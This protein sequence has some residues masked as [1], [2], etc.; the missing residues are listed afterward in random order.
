MLYE[1][2]RV[3]LYDCKMLTT[4]ESVKKVTKLIVPG[5]ESEDRSEENK[6]QLKA[7]AD[8]KYQSLHAALDNFDQERLMAF[9][10]ICCGSVYGARRIIVSYSDC[11][12]LPSWSTCIRTMYIGRGFT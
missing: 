10:K 1:H 12:V 5:L 2:V 6:I 3:A 8:A 9:V 7:A 11:D 4:H